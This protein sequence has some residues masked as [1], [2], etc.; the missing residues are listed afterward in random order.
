MDTTGAN[1]ATVV[2]TPFGIQ[3]VVPEL[4]NVPCFRNQAR[5]PVSV[6]PAFLRPSEE[7]RNAMTLHLESIG[8][9]HNHF[10][11]S[12]KDQRKKPELVYYYE[13]L[14]FVCR[15]CV[16][17]FLAAQALFAVSR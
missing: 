16:A 14:L 6:A 8:L 15:E 10:T 9:D 11:Y 2:N 12:V 7:S 1:H 17:A 5:P 4:Q 3:S 13:T